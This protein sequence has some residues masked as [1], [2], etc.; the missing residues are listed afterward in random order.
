MLRAIILV[1]AGSVLIT[2]CATTTGKMSQSGELLPI[3]Q[4]HEV[5][6]LAVLDQVEFLLPDGTKQIG[7]LD[8]QGVLRLLTPPTRGVPTVSGKATGEGL[9]EQSKAVPEVKQQTDTSLVLL[10]LSVPDAEKKLIAS[11]PRITGI[12]WIEYRENSVSVLG[13]VFNQTKVDLGESPFRVLDAVAAAGGFTPLAQLRNVVLVRRN[14]GNVKIF[15][16]DLDAATRGISP[17]FN[18]LVAPG[19]V[20]TVRRSLL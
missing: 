3:E 14:A 7:R 11:F 13:E 2:G 18:I 5:Y 1:F 20:I 15:I 9:S 19:D 16:L 4:K 17:Q 6:H 8:A 12:H 10:G